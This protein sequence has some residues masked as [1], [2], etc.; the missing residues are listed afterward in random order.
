VTSTAAL[1]AAEALPPAYAETVTRI[2]Q[3]TPFS[4]VMVDAL[5]RTEA[6][7]HLLPLD[8][9][10]R[11][12]RILYITG[13]GATPGF[14][15]TIAAVAA[16]SFVEVE[17]VDI[18]FGVGIANWEA[19]RATIRED[20]L[21]LPGFNAEKVAAMSD[22]DVEAELDRRNGLIELVNME[23]ADDIILELAGVCPR[24]RITV[25]G[26]VDTR[27]AKKPISTQVTVTGRVLSGESCSHVFTVADATTMV[28][29]VCGPA[30]G[31]MNRG[32]SLH[33]RGMYGLT[34]S[35]ELMP[36][37]TREGVSVA[38]V[39]SDQYLTAV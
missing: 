22:A 17:A 9:L 16:Q 23:H 13:A 27:N 15:T 7:E 32:L 5:K 37:V 34:T 18:R 14:L 20:L 31:F 28:D 29:N 8:G 35:A 24:D 21:H 2:A 36:R 19:Y 4:G 10:L 30:V 6:V 11:S 33:N 12:R 1:I 26:L 39:N 25:G 3:E 38:Q